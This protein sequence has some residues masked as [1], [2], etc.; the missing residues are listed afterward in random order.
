MISAHFYKKMHQKAALQE[1]LLI[2]RVCV[3]TIECRICLLKIHLMQL[4]FYASTLKMNR[5]A[6]DCCNG[7]SFLLF[8]LLRKHFRVCIEY[9]YVAFFIALNL[10]LRKVIF[11]FLHTAREAFEFS[12][13]ICSHRTSVGCRF[14]DTV[15]W[16]PRWS[17][18]TARWARH[19]GFFT[20]QWIKEIGQ[21]TFATRTAG[22]QSWLH[23]TQWE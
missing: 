1:F 23:L 13:R 4:Q 8:S 12:G 6:H 18:Y 11:A 21:H 17:S 19:I 5:W 7:F 9:N 14:A 22:R 16:W 2:L 20:K 3:F 15:C 10:R